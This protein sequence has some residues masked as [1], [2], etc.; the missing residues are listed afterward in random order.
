MYL[1]SL[2]IKG[3]SQ[4]KNS[5]SS[6]GFTHSTAIPAGVEPVQNTRQWCQP[7]NCD[8]QFAFLGCKQI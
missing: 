1:Y 4:K 6:E 8:I 5:S 3:E 7:F 2:Q